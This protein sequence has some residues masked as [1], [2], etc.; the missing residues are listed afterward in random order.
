MAANGSKRGKGAKGSRGARTTGPTKADFKR[1]SKEKMHAGVKYVLVGIGILAMVLSVSTMAC[2]G[3]LNQVSSNRGY[4]LTGGVAATVD[5]VNITEDT[6]TEQIMTTRQTLGYTEDADWASYLASSGMTPESYRESLIDSYARQYLLS[7]A[8]GEYGADAT[9]EQI[10]E[11]WQDVVAGYDSEEAFLEQLGAVGYTEDS[12]KEQLA[13][14]IAQE[15]L[16]EAVAPS[17]EPSDDDVVAYVNENLDTYNDARRS[18]HIL[19]KVAEDA[20]DA[21]R[22]E[23]RATA[24]DVL[25]RINS[26]ELSFEDAV[27]E[28][29]EDS[30]ADD[31]GDVGW[32]KLTTFVTEYQDALSALGEGEM[33]GLVETT[34]GYHIILCTDYFHVDGS[35]SSVD[36]IPED[37]R[38]AIADTVASEKQ[39]AA[40][41]EWLNGYV[42]SA[43]I[44]INPM[45]ENVPYNVDMSLAGS[46]E[47]SSGSAETE[48]STEADAS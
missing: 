41:N 27:S 32:D 10:E 20:D 35:V 40:Y 3:V 29:S 45:P 21:T 44:E 16:R 36:Q 11:E 1:E 7:R 25:D 30:S 46:A 26:G 43:D 4:E 34:Y 6:I 39:A 13:S 8:V 37:L 22:E 31:G 5:G 19:F 38:A 42:E 17:E 28:Y 18:S 2:A 23:A 33:S 14:S 48:G 47:G 9:D 15:N 24:Q 12:Y